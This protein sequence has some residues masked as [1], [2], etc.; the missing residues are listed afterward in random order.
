MNLMLRLLAILA[1]LVLLVA[2]PNLMSG[3][4]EAAKQDTRARVGVRE[5]PRDSELVRSLMAEPLPDALGGVNRV[6]WLLYAAGRSDEAQ[7]LQTFVGACNVLR[8]VAH[9]D[10]CRRETVATA[11]LKGRG[12]PS[13]T[14]AE[15]VPTEIASNLERALTFGLPER[16]D[17]RAITDETSWQTLTYER[18]GIVHSRMA[19]TYFFIAARNTS[20][21][22]L[23][24]VQALVSLRLA[25]GSHVELKCS[26]RN[27]FPF[28]SPPVQSGKLAVAHCAP[29]EGAS[30]DALSE[31]WRGVS[32]AS[33]NGIHWVQLDQ[34]NPY[35]RVQRRGAGPESSLEIVPIVNLL[36]ELRDRAM[37][38]EEARL[39]HELGVLD[40]AKI[41]TC[42][43]ASLAAAVAF[44][45]PF[46][47]NPLL[48]PVSA[49]LLLGIAV[50]GLFRRPLRAGVV[51][52][53][54]LVAGAA[55]TL[56]WAGHA[57]G[58]HGSDRGLA[59]NDRGVRAGSTGVL[60]DA[61]MHPLDPHPRGR[62]RVL[63]RRGVGPTGHGGAAVA[64]AVI[65]P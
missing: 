39:G 31:A 13:R 11:V 61:R 37:G 59:L 19:A 52:A 32:D 65:S 3:L 9:D 17:F 50:G 40:C 25:D 55:L 53:G 18:S 49:A 62:G 27:P 6:Y 58:P 21:W 28:S 42:P 63:T 30:I 64:R 36:H 10:A 29:P 2:V 56:A 48:L 47:A 54:V 22:Q 14:K 38:E 7:A 15:P 24:E 33:C 46:S 8:L 35:V 26:T 57:V 4:G 16:E 12:M 41:N 1:I 44:S 51:V 20:P 60:P 43:P 23:G 45:R 34:Q 5:I